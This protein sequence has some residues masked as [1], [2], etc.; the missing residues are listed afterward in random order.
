MLSLYPDHY[1]HRIWNLP[2]EWLNEHKIK[3]LLLDVDNT[4]TTHNNPNVPQEVCN[5]LK[6]INKQGISS[7]ILSNNHAKRVA[8]FAQKLNI[9]YVANAAK[10]LSYGVKRALKHLEAEPSCVALI[11]DQ[12]FTDILCAKSAGIRSILVEPM[13]KEPYIFFKLKRKLEK[14][15]LQN[16]HKGERL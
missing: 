2:V 1:V 10:P 4:L 6:K 13:E 12:L 16:Y 5:W 15:L 11:G 14:K 3:V 7:Y 9:G 8:P